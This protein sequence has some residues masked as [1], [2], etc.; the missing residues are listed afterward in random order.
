M[1]RHTGVAPRLITGDDPKN[2]HLRE[3][4]GANDRLML[5]IDDLL[6][7]ESLSNAISGCDG[8]FHYAS[9]ITDDHVR[10]NDGPSF[11]GT[12]NVI[13]AS[14]ET[15]ARRVVFTS[16]IGAV[17][18]YP[19][20]DPDEVI[21]EDCWSDLEFCNPSRTGTATEKQWQKKL[22]C[23]GKAVAEKSAS[24][25]AKERGVDM[26]VI[27]PVLVLGPLL[28]PTVNANIVHILKYLTSSVKT[29]VNL[30]WLEKLEQFH[31]LLEEMGRNG[32]SPDYYTFNILLH[33]LGKGDKPLASLN[34]L[35][36]MKE[37]GTDA[38]VLHFTTLIDGMSRAGNLDTRAG[39]NQKYFTK[40]I[41]KGHVPNVFTYNSMIR[42]LCMAGMFKEACMMLEDMESRGCNLNFLVYNTLVSYLRNAGKISETN[43]V[44]RVMVRK[45]RYVDLISKFKHYR[46]C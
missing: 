41:V 38:S 16:S 18:M 45:G 19:N 31:R 7:Y 24:E 17:Y 28:Q 14:A 29:Y 10:T 9:P 20:R 33:V 23:Y 44:I 34:L 21:N 27:G 6:D 4:E 26:V 46:R 22:V 15:K 35:N 5:C 40:M 1:L 37:V 32:F 11:I 2:G 43:E 13:V 39:D 25:E 36:Q 12:R 8:V 3:L 42:V 30:V